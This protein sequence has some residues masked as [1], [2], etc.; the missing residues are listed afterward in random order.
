MANRQESAAA[1]AAIRELAERLQNKE[2]ELHQ[3]KM[4]LV[5]AKD[6]YAIDVRLKLE[7]LV[8]AKKIRLGPLPFATICFVPHSPS[9][10]NAA[11]PSC[12]DTNAGSPP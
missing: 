3:A 2:T 1:A 11:F 4:D 10:S 9:P 6:K 5:T 8:F 12:T 7:S